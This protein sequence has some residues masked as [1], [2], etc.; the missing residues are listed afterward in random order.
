MTSRWYKL[1][2]DTPVPVSA[3]EVDWSNRWHLRD[4]VGESV[5]STVFIPLDHSFDGGDPVLFETLIFG[6]P[7]ADEGERYHTKAQAKAGHAKWM[8]RVVGETNDQD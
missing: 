4:T 2:G 7:L 1:D 3:E 6:G 8:A 5:V